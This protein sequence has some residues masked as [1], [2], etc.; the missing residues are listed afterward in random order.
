MMAAAALALAPMPVSAA[1]LL[2]KNAQIVDP[3]AETTQPGAFVIGG[4]RIN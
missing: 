1:D 2:N 3:V 4:D